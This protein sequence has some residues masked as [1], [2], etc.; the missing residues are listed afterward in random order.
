M[1]IPLQSIAMD[2]TSLTLLLTS[3]QNG[4]C[5][6]NEALDQLQGFPEES[7]PDACVDHQRQLRTGIPEVIFGAS[8]T[9]K[10]ISAIAEAL[11]KKGGPVIV[12]KVN[13][14]KGRQIQKKIPRLL[15]NSQAQMLTYTQSPQD[16]TQYKGTTVIVCA[17]TSDIPI[18]EEARLTL[19]T[20]GHS[21]ETLY[22]TG[23][24]GLHRLLSHQKILHEAA[25]IIVVAGMEGA[26]PSVVGGLVKCPV[27]AVP[28]SIG[29]GTSFGG[30][31]ALLGMLNSCVPGIG[32]VNIDNGF[33]AA[34]LADAINRL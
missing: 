10:Q 8:K 14:E 24:A 27:I 5:S 22:D 2:A 15:F 28:T 18:A 31:T 11:F 12:T 29:Y 21:V 4:T 3:I 9:V 33:G 34:C 19:E 16:D 30:V 7:I 23:V 26:L 25:V 20:L 32:V 6:I 17:G 13:Q 1:V